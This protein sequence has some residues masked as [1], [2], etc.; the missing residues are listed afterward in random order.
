MKKLITSG[1]EFEQKYAY[2]RAVV[3][4]QWVFVSGTTGYDYLTM[5]ISD[6]V[7]EQTEQC[8]KNIQKALAE[9]GSDLSEVVRIHYILPNKNDFQDCAAVIQKHLSE[10][11]PAATMIEAGLIDDAMKLEIEVTAV[12]SKF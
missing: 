12:K 10:S 8:F 4:D 3:Q 11:R 9:A 6:S 5:T 1:S 2:S 7:A